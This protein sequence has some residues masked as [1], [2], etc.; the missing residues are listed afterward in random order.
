[1]SYS[2]IKFILN[3]V[4]N[5]R[6]AAIL[7]VSEIVDHLPE[8][9]ALDLPDFHFFLHHVTRWQFIR[10]HPDILEFGII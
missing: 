9:S 8:G 1:M 5:I 6:I 7:F 4:S 2:F 10:L 3:I